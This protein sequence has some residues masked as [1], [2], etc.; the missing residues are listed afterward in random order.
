M[1]NTLLS[2]DTSKLSRQDILIITIIAFVA[3]TLFSTSSF[4]YDFNRWVDANCIFTVGKSIFCGKVPYKDLM[5]HKGFLLHLINGIG[6][7]ISFKTFFGVYIM[8]LIAGSA[9]LLAC[10]KTLLLFTDRKVLYL[11]PFLALGAFGPGCFQQGASAEEF[12]LPFLAFSFY[13]GLRSIKSQ[14]ELT[15]REAFLMGI[16]AS[17]VFWIKYTICGLFAGLWIGLGFFYLQ[18]NSQKQLLKTFGCFCVGLLPISI[19]IILY[20]AFNHALSDLW[21]VYFYNNIFNYTIVPGRFGV[22]G[23]LARHE[24]M[25]M[26][27]IMGDRLM[28]CML[29]GSLIELYLQKN[30]KVL[31]FSLICCLCMFVMI[32]AGIPMQYYPLPLGIGL[33]FSLLLALRICKRLSTTG[34]Y[35][36]YTIAMLLALTFCF[37]INYGK[38][39]WLHNRDYAAVNIGKMIMKEE[40]H[41]PTMIEYGIMDIGVYTVCGYIPECKHFCH[42][43][44]TIKE[45]ID[46][47][48]K[49]IAT[50]HPTYIISGEPK[51]FDGYRL[52]STQTQEFG[53]LRNFLHK[54]FPSIKPVPNTKTEYYV[55]RYNNPKAL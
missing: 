12:C 5:D 50:R 44:L 19:A 4:L 48:D 55:Y 23:N 20:F 29:I 21:T 1:S 10:Y 22:L 43:N 18:N 40:E 32:F 38:F 2:N 24:W 25:G 8:E 52:I 35:I 33:P 27:G 28:F 37:R 51:T 16:F 49:F 42:L 47:Q 31:S 34:N 15:L 11:M 13:I 46:A 6:S 39:F 26:Q 45:Q 14:K 7:L 3:V 41:S 53:I 54:Y 36:L 30:K 9:F 17:C